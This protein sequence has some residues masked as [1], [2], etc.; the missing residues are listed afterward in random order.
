MNSTGYRQPLNRRLFDTG[1]M[2]TIF[3]SLMMCMASLYRN[4]FHKFSGKKKNR[5]PSLPFMT[6]WCRIWM[7]VIEKNKLLAVYCLLSHHNFTCHIYLSGA[8][9]LLQSIFFLPMDVFSVLRPRICQEGG[10][11][12]MLMRIQRYAYICL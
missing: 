4:K 5:I 8:K 2:M 3:Y 11:Q 7:T 10:N 12:Q 6:T 9:Y 1:N